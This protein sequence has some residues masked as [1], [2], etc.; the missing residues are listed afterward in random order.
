M[1]DELQLKLGK[2]KALE[3]AIASLVSSSGAPPR[4]AAAGDGARDRQA[5]CGGGGG[6]A[7][8]DLAAAPGPGLDALLQRQRRQQQLAPPQPTFSFGVAPAAASSPNP[9]HGEV[10]RF[11]EY[12]VPAAGLT[13]TNTPSSSN[14][15]TDTASG[16]DELDALVPIMKIVAH[17]VGS[18]G[19]A[20]TAQALRRCLARLEPSSLHASSS[21]SSLSPVV[22]ALGAPGLS[23]VLARHV[24][25]G[26]ALAR[27]AMVSRDCW[28]AARAVPAYWTPFS[29]EYELWR[30]MPSP[31]W[32]RYMEAALEQQLAG[33]LRQL[34]VLE[35][36]LRSQVLIDRAKNHQEQLL[37]YD[38]VW[39]LS[40][41]NDAEREDLSS[42]EQLVGEE[43]ESLR[44]LCTPQSVEPQDRRARYQHRDNLEGIPDAAYRRLARRTG[45]QRF[46]SVVYKA[47]RSAL[48]DFLEHLLRYVVTY[49]EHDRRRT[50]TSTD[51]A[52]GLQ[53]AGRNCTAA[54]STVASTGGFFERKA[55]VASKNDQDSS[56]LEEDDLTQ[57]L[58]HQQ[59]LAYLYHFEEL[60][61]EM[62]QDFMVQCGCFACHCDCSDTDRI[63]AGAV[64]RPVD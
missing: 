24:Q 32:P 60:H 25:T 57:P 58:S 21:S 36:E 64:I 41:K 29:A 53:L 28:A 26:V 17:A 42:L 27:F 30:A 44:A 3:R 13:H 12:A 37:Q 48:R 15:A 16:L 51:I 19:K 55:T 2:R 1:R 34:P 35:P 49:A 47:A 43:S 56:E 9:A 20:H 45:V 40:H 62:L 33:Y 50:V 61:R 31:S 63:L 52:H 7:A 5:S 8:T 6:S 54:R 22:E 23:L 11:G 18:R 10:Y 46:S 59:V 4:G 14:A 39:T 38:P